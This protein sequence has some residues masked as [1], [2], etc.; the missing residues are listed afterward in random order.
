MLGEKES[1]R[2]TVIVLV[3]ISLIIGLI[4]RTGLQFLD[5]KFELAV[6]HIPTIFSMI[7]YSQIRE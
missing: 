5:P 6:F 1:W 2:L 3:V 7:I 4:Q